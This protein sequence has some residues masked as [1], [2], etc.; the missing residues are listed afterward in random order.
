MTKALSNM[1]KDLKTYLAKSTEGRVSPP[2]FNL[3]RYSNSLKEFCGLIAVSVCSHWSHWDR[4]IIFLAAYPATTAATCFASWSKVQH[5]KSLESSFNFALKF[6]VSL[7]SVLLG[8]TSS[9]KKIID[10]L[11]RLGVQTF[12]TLT[13][14]TRVGLTLVFEI[15]PPLL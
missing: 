14:F 4:L 1:A 11:R 10:S 7:L 13:W 12:A 3:E 2:R 9:F 6:F 15:K 5:S 8:W